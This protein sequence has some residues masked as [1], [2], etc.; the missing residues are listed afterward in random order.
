MK[1][2][3]WGQIRRVVVVALIVAGVAAVSVE[4]SLLAQWPLQPDSRAPRTADG[5]VNLKAPTPRTSDGKPDLSGV[6]ETV[7][8][9]SG[10][11][12][13]GPDTHPLKRTSQFWNIGA[14][15]D[16][17]LPSSPG[18]S[19]CARVA[20]PPTARTIQMRT[21]CRLASRS[22]TIIHSRARS[23]RRRR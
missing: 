20:W 15:L 18:H 23:S 11:V 7:R 12:I 9:G 2:S 5:Q 3:R 8:D 10:Q 4:P 17:D 13:A 16:G 6:W 14:G 19:S 1:Q 21:A 22:C